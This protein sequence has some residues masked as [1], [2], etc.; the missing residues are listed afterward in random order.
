M[1]KTQFKFTLARLKAL[2][3][4]G[5]RYIVRDTEIPGLQ[6]RVSPTGERSLSIYKR[7][8]GKPNPVR[9]KIHNTGSIA[10]IQSEA[11]ANISDLASGIN[12]NERDKIEAI[13]N[14]TLQDAFNQFEA[15]KNLAKNTIKKYKRVMANMD[16]WKNRPLQDITRTMVLERFNKLEE[17]GPS[18]AREM[19]QL[20][21]AVWNFQ[22]DLT[23]NDDFGRSPTI[24]LNKQKKQWAKAGTRN[25][26]I[27]TD[28]LP[29]W[30][31]AVRSLPNMRG[32]GKRMAAYL[33]F[34]LLTGLRRREASRLKWDDVNMKAGYFIVRQTK[35]KRDHCL[36]ITRRTKQL[37]R[38]MRDNGEFVYGVND[39]QRAIKRVRNV[40]GVEFTS[41]DLRR[42]F[43]TLADH[44][45][46]GGY[47]IK[48][49]LNHAAGNDVTGAHYA[50][51]KPL[52]STGNVDLSEVKSM[53]ESLQKIE[54]YI[55][56]Q[57]K[58]HRDNVL[59]V[60]K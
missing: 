21:S 24:I 44:S 22:N 4:T 57:A 53:R 54:D 6:C 41:H 16:A 29:E 17:R 35:N 47:A 45:G 52:D 55:L 51:Y 26:K 31:D 1:D 5:N 59:E 37:L 10:A 49:V 11:L 2:P 7:P 39:P 40:C 32:D 27:P 14:V 60:V 38:L 30:V 23:D 56:S 33:E 9:V 3:A 18:V 43:T 50:A 8:R 48:G 28:K 12:P 25:R 46:A 42:T 34:L 20:L 19:G 58:A 13:L 15:S 36:P